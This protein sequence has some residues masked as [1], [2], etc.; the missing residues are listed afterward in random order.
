MT[1]ELEDY[2]SLRKTKKENK[3]EGVNEV[4]RII[5]LGGIGE[6][7]KNM[8]AIEWGESMIVIDCG[9]CFPG[10]ELLGVDYVIPDT[11]YLEA[12]RKKLKAFFI[13]HGHE[14]H[15]GATPYVCKQFPN[16]PVFASRLTIALIQ[17]KFEE[18]G[19]SGI[20]L[21]TVKPGGTINMGP[22]KVEFIKVCHSIDDAMGFAIHTPEGVIVHT[23]DFKVD[24]TP[25]D[26]KIIDLNKF[27]DLG[28][29]GVLA[30]MSDSTNAER[31]GYTVSEKTVGNSFEQYF[32][33]AEG[34]IIIATFSSNI[35]RLQQVVDSARAC[36]R[37]IA[38]SGRSMVRFANVATELGYLKMPEKMLVEIE[39]TKK[40]KDNK[41]V[42]LT[43]GSQGEP[44]SGLVRMASGDHSQIVIKQGDTVII[45]STPIPGNEKYVSGV[46]NMLYRRGA[47]VIYGKSASVHVS[48]HACREEL[49]LMLAL[50][51]PKYFIPVHGEYRHLYSH[52]ELAESMGY[53]SKN[54][55][56]EMGRPIEF[57]GKKASFGEPVQAGSV[58]IDGL[59]IGDVGNVV[60]RDRKQLSSDGMV[61]IIINMSKTTGKL[62]GDVEIISCGFIYVKESEE[63]IEGAKKLITDTVEEENSSNRN[64]RIALKGKVKK[65]VSNY[66]YNKTK[67]RPM[68][69]PIIME[70]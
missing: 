64:E 36:G 47:E 46:I 22:F 62:I 45:S 35:H 40:V 8:T 61:L 7:G 28:R 55:F 50:T 32:P 70:V 42:I 12:N 58:L 23:G 20:N 26:G 65:E 63:L 27:A 16:V 1:I 60:L 68:I 66:L 21:C 49:K 3:Q 30:L 59:G 39:D 31:E 9:L 52:A 2:V 48:G 14:D 24:F 11:T 56:P 69:I 37:K 6:I 38:F 57:S 41:L 19:I 10:E 53:K 51:K 67:R 29:R 15:I 34:R 25:V 44:M 43:T 13:T 33:D 54:I 4:L 18:S 17:E 5:P